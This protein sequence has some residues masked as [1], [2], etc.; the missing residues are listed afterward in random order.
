[1]ISILAVTNCASSVLSL[2][3]N[4]LPYIM[5]PHHTRV[6]KLKMVQNY[7][8]EKKPIR[9]S[10]FTVCLLEFGV[11]EISATLAQHWSNFGSMS[12][13][14]CEITVGVLLSVSML[15][16]HHWAIH[17]CRLYR[18]V[19]ASI[20]HPIQILKHS[21]ALCPAQLTAISSRFLH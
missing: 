10:E 16:R 6:Y 1:M 12:H 5:K 19:S 20:T 2:C 13:V 8:S 14:G 21:G 11:F 9:N 4:T 17:D 7:R 3:P 15:V 18:R